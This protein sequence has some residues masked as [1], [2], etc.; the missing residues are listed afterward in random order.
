[1]RADEGRGDARAYDGS[2]DLATASDRALH[3]RS[4]YKQMEKRIHGSAWT[5]QELMVLVLAKRLD[6][7]ITSAF[8]T[9]MDGLDAQLTARLAQPDDA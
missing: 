6:V 3:V 8:A 2:M 7:D 5:P 9:T 1:V 4:L